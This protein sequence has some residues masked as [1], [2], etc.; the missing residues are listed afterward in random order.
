MTMGYIFIIFDFYNLFCDVALFCNPRWSGNLY[1]VKIVL[2]ITEILLS[3]HLKC[4][5]Y[6][7]MLYHA[8]HVRFEKCRIHF[9]IFL[10]NISVILFLDIGIGLLG[11]NLSLVTLIWGFTH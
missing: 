1:I 2:E 8:L 10:N 11:S 3:Q 9:Y 7:S 6:I 4:W 5:D